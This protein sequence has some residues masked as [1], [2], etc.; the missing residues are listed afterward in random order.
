MSSEGRHTPLLVKKIKAK[1]IP[2]LGV[3]ILDENGPKSTRKLVFRFWEGETVKKILQ[4]FCLPS[5]E[6]SSFF[7]VF[8]FSIQH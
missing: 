5:W 7:T 3:Q 4:N 2:P 8:G 6:I 1:I